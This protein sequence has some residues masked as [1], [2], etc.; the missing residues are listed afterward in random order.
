MDHLRDADFGPF[1]ISVVVTRH[2]VD[3]LDEFKALADSYGAQLRIT[4]LRPSGRGADA[5]H[6]LH[7]T[8][9]QQRQI[10]EWLIE[11][12]D[13]V[14][15]GD[16]FFHLNALGDENLPG[17]N[18]CGAGRVVCLIDP[19]GDV[20]ACPFV[21]H[22]EFK[23]GNVRD[24]GGFSH[25][26]KRS[27]LFRELREPQSAGAC[28]SCGSYDACQGGC[29]AAKFFTGIPLDGPDPECVSGH[30]E[31]AMAGVAN[32]SA[33]RPMMDHSKPAR[34]TPVTLGRR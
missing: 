4:R 22:D 27:D 1:K 25:V 7:P 8:N 11:H 9:A 23:A 32:G 21:I 14:L 13:Q 28:A 6:D 31:V 26:W 10:Y 18:L 30:G 16:S 15:T 33:P 5:W 12:G 20:Y 29:M 17:L 24:I 34:P 3:Q 19:I 2:N